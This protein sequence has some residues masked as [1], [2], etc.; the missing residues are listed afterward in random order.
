[1]FPEPKFHFRGAFVAGRFSLCRERLELRDIM[2]AQLA[3]ESENIHA[4]K[5]LL[6]VSQT[7]A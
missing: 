5:I 3:C 7:R 1:L 6:K 4:E 2:V